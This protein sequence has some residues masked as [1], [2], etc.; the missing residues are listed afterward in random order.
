MEVAK[1]FNCAIVA[2]FDSS[3]NWNNVTANCIGFA[4]VRD[5]DVKKGTMEIIT[6][7][8]IIN[9]LARVAVVVKSSEVALSKHFYLHH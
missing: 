1:H 4:L 7:N 2:L 6:S 8:S 5:I 3:F 9:D